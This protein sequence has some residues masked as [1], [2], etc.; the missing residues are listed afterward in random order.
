MGSTRLPGKILKTVLGKSLLEYQIE[1][2]RRANKIDEL[3]L[4]TT[5]NPLDDQLVDLCQAWGLNCFRGDEDD[6]LDRYYRAACKYEA[7]AVV[8]ITSDCPLIDPDVVDRVIGCFCENAPDYDYVSNIMERTYPRGMDCEVFSM[9]ALSRAFEAAVGG[10]REHVTQFMYNRQ[11]GFRLLGVEHSSDQS[12][13]RWTVDTVEDFEL[14]KRIL[15]ALYPQKPNFS[16][17]DCLELVA[18]H[19]EWSEIN[20][21]I[22]QKT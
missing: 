20:R 6:V 4:A 2:L 3:V 7:E 15:K 13:H 17:E 16:L 9:A 18:G 10:E 1:R 22:N 21:H 14:I 11:N 19:P 12:I 5:T 8:R